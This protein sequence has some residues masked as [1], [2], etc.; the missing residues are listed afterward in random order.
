MLSQIIT[1]TGHIY[2]TRF[3]NLRM[4]ILGRDFR[5]ETTFYWWQLT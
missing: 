2:A 4:K 5:I 1:Y 3:L